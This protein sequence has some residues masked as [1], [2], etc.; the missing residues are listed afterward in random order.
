MGDFQVGVNDNAVAS[1]YADVDSRVVGSVVQQRVVPLDT[2]VPSCAWR[3]SIPAMSA[4][5][6]VSPQNLFSLYNGSPSNCLE[7]REVHV[8]YFQGAT[9]LNN[10][11]GQLYAPPPML[12]GYK[13]A[14]APTLGT[15][16]TARKFS[17]H[18]SQSSHASV[19]VRTDGGDFLDATVAA[20]ALQA[21]VIGA[22][23]SAPFGHAMLTKNWTLAGQALSPN[24]R[25]VGD[26]DPQYLPIIGP[27]EGAVFRLEGIATTTANPS[28]NLYSAEIACRE[29]DPTL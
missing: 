19:V 20:S 4:R 2:I 15:D 18:P 26:L 28:Q 24:N 7:L 9:G 27:G 29:F 16:I 8:E 11:S 17:A 13:V 10:P 3:V 22:R 25:V 12:R 5:P 14:A 23:A 6:S 1:G 21:S